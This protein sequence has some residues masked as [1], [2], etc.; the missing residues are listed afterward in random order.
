MK[1]H[2]TLCIYN[3][4]MFLSAALDSI[5]EHVDSIIV[6]DGAYQLYY[7]NYLNYD[8]TVKP[9]STDGSL[10]II[11]AFKD[12]PP[13]K[14]IECPNG[15][16]WV[17]QAVKRTALVDAVPDGDWFIIVDADHVLKGDIDEGMEEIYDSGCVAAR[18]PWVNVGLDSER[19]EIY[20]HPLIFEKMAG[21]NYR[22]THWHLRDK[23]DRII[24]EYYPV[25][26][27]NRFVYVHLK[28]FKRVDRILP[29]QDYMRLLQ[30]VGW[31]EPNGNP[32][33]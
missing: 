26:W 4:R 15:E 31:I 23:F 18:V 5:R 7:D 29:H 32:V 21:M 3:D 8:S 17:N 1:L 24:E 11:E 25:K 19:M 28:A 13:T 10:E 9:W 2:A 16:P 6:A 12:L 33:Q 14:L 30:P 27:T 22:H 20:W